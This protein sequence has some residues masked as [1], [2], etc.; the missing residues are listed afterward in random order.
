MK[1]NRLTIFLVLLVVAATSGYLYSIY[2]SG[3]VAE[4]FEDSD[5]D[6]SAGSETKKKRKSSGGG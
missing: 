5:S 3:N 2:P 6:G 4:R 1:S